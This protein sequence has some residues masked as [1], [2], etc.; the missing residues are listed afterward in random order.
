MDYPGKD[1]STKRQHLRQIADHLDK[2]VCFYDMELSQGVE[3][4]HRLFFELW[5]MDR[6]FEY[7]EVYYWQKLTGIVLNSDEPWMFLRI[8]EKCIRFLK[9]KMKDK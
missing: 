5:R 4:Y 7:S 8:S 2:P 9:E 6:G 3:Y 1:G